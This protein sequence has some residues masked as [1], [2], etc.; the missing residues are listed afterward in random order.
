MPAGTVF[1]Y[2]GPDLSGPVD[3]SAQT[4]PDDTKWTVTSEP[5]G[6][7]D[8]GGWCRSQNAALISENTTS[9][10]CTLRVEGNWHGAATLGSRIGVAPMKWIT[11]V[12][13]SPT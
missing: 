4:Y 8:G 12:P 11:L 5:W 2:I 3:L 13:P 6:Y 7:V 1:E 10:V 9:P